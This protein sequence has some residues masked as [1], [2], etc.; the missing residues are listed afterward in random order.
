MKLQG[1]KASAIAKNPLC[2]PINISSSLNIL[3]AK[4]LLTS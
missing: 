1:Q 3:D 2:V 4:T